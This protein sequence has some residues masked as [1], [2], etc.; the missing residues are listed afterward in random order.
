MPVGGEQG[1]GGYRGEGEGADWEGGKEGYEV[2]VEHSYHNA[3]KAVKGGKLYGSYKPVSKQHRNNPISDSLSRRIPSGIA[4]EGLFDW[5]T[6]S[7]RERRA[8]FAGVGDSEGKMPWRLMTKEA[9]DRAAA[10]ENEKREA[11]R[12]VSTAG[13]RREPE[14]RVVGGV[15]DAED[16]EEEMAEMNADRNQPMMEEED[17]NEPEAV[18]DGFLPGE[19]EARSEESKRLRSFVGSRLAGVSQDAMRSM[20]QST[21][22][23]IKWPVFGSAAQ[24]QP[25]EESTPTP[26]PQSQPPQPQQPP[27][28]PPPAPAQPK[29]QEPD[30][31]QGWEGN[32][33]RH[34]PESVDH[35]PQT[36]D[37]Q[38]GW[39]GSDP[40]LAPE[41]VDHPPPSPTP[42]NSATSSD[43]ATPRP[44]PLPAAEE[45]KIEID[46]FME[47]IRKGQREAETEALNEA[48]REK[49]RA[50]DKRRRERK[51]AA[52]KASKSMDNVVPEKMGVQARAKETG[53]F[54]PE[55]ELAQELEKE[56]ET[57]KA[58]QNALGLDGGKVI[59]ARPVFGKRA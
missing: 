4:K 35:P 53:T 32:D 24:E 46:S 40:H 7:P 10:R 57:S 2:T 9:R 29:E 58:Y 18:D 39:D 50:Y 19:G 48:E 36:T 16:L 5:A 42:S 20:R 37:N 27:P 22:S 43:S 6:D 34:T 55:Q 56:L 28:S 33:P 31:Q 17:M 1:H 25:E 44:A 13:R 8:W 38:A 26:K 21:T 12:R 49:R 14:R 41:S 30:N 52:A 45:V 54:D 51:K 11:I 23:A 3:G 15:A 47:A 59:G